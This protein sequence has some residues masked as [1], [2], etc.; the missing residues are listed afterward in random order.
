MHRDTFIRLKRA[1]P[2]SDPKSEHELMVFS[3]TDGRAGQVDHNDVF[4]LFAWVDEFL[5]GVVASSSTPI[6]KR[7]SISTSRPRVLSPARRDMAWSS[8]T[9]R[10]TES[11]WAI[12]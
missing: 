9:T 5:V 3:S 4:H 8:T 6:P 10:V 2:P 11:T 1:G 7:V 12:S